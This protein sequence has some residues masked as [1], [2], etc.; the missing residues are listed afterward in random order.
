MSFFGL[1]LPLDV[2][3]H[4]I[5]FEQRRV[6][7]ISQPDPETNVR[8]F[9]REQSLRRAKGYLKAR[10]IK[11]WDRWDFTDTAFRRMLQRLRG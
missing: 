3:P 2:V 9:L 5:R 11:P 10:G 1:S 8:R 7:G 4:S 6:S